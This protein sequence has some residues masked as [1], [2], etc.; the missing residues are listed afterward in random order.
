MLKIFSYLL[1]AGVASVYSMPAK[2]VFIDGKMHL[3]AVELNHTTIAI[4]AKEGCSLSFGLI[5]LG[6][7]NACYVYKIFCTDVNSNWKVKARQL[8]FAILNEYTSRDD[9]IALFSLKVIYRDGYQADVNQYQLLTNIAD[10]RFEMNE[11]YNAMFCGGN[12]A[13]FR[14]DMIE[15][16]PNLED[17]ICELIPQS[18]YVPDVSPEPKKS[19]SSFVTSIF[20]AFGNA[21][22]ATSCRSGDANKAGGV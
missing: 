9:P 22:V 12:R 20:N 3:C 2:V 14:Q 19:A 6:K 4:D 8:G 13:K 16:F 5:D 17:Q 18:L 1:V 15:K 11:D 10:N 7:E 21:L